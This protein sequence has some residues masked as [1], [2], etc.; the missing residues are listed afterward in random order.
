[1][2]D[3]FASGDRGALLVVLVLVLGIGTILILALAMFGK[4]DRTNQRVNA[5]KQRWRTSTPS[6][7]RRLLKGRSH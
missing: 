3:A 1:M 7:V 6:I 4:P 2:M 5:I